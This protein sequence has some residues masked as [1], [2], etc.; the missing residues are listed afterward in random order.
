VESVTENLGTWLEDV[1]TEVGKGPGPRHKRSRWARPFPRENEEEASS[2]CREEAAWE[3]SWEASSSSPEKPLEGGPP[4]PSLPREEKTSEKRAQEGG[5]SPQRGR[6]EYPEVLGWQPLV[7]N[8][9]Q[10][11]AGCGRLLVQGDRAHLGLTQ[12]GVSGLVLCDACMDGGE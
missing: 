12:K 3:N 10:A 9:P 4:G 6:P 1:A 8:R 2:R 11:C 7:M 5:A